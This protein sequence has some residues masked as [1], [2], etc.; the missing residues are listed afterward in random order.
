M[1]IKQ[2]ENAKGLVKGEVSHCDANWHF[3]LKIAILLCRSREPPNAAVSYQAFKPPK[4]KQHPG[5]KLR[6]I[7]HTLAAMANHDHSEE[8]VKE[9]SIILA[10]SRPIRIAIQHSS[11]MSDPKTPRSLIHN[12]CPTLY[13]R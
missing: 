1:Q 7:D 8:A 11:T 13:H 9:F 2:T 6:S 3:Q 4:E 12:K 5:D 10:L